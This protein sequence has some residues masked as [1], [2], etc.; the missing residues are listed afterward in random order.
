VPSAAQDANTIDRLSHRSDHARMPTPCR[1]LLLALLACGSLAVHAQQGDAAPASAASAATPAQSLE[2]LDDRLDALKAALKDKQAASSLGDLRNDALAV[3][4]QARQLASDLAPQLAALQA[5]LDVL[6]PPPAKGAAPE[7]PQVAAQRRQ[8]DKAGAALDARIKQAQLLGQNALQLA[9]QITGMRNDAFQARLA[10]R[11]ASPFGRAFWSEPARS[12]P[13][14]LARLD[15]LGGR[16][17]DAWSEAWETPN[18]TP[19]L[20]CLIGAL[21][22]LGVGRWLL[23]RLLWRLATRHVPDGHLRRSAM[24][25]A[26]A[27]TALLTTGIAAQLAYLGLNWNDILAPDL[28]ALARSAVR[29]VLFAAFVTGLGR[30]LLSVRRPSWRL[31]PLSDL[32]AQRL[33]MLPWLLGAAALLFGLVERISR[34]IGSSLPTTVATR[35]AVALVVSGLIAAGW[36]RLRGARRQAAAEGVV[37]HQPLWV[38][39]LGAGAVL[40]VLVSWLGVATGYIALAFFAA[41]QMLWVGV[42]VA[43]AWLLGHLLNDLIHVA[44]SPHERGGQRLQ[45][46]FQLAP[47]ALD[48]AATLLAGIAK[49][50]LTLLAI[51]IVLTPFGA[52][53]GDLLASAL[54]T[55]GNLKLG[56]LP[57][58]PGNIFRAVLVLVGGGV[59]LHMLKRWLREQLLPKSTM[60]PGMQDSIVTLLGYLGGL[61]VLVLTLAALHVNLTSITWIVSALSV[62]IGFGLQAIVQ[63]FISGL[64]LLVERPVKVGD[65]VSLNEVEGDIRRINVRATEIQLWDRSTVIVP[66]SQL[67]TENVRN[68]TQANAL[69]RVQIK[70]PMPLDTDADKVRALALEVLGAHPGTLAAPAP[71]VQLE[72]LDAG[73]MTFNCV[74]YVGSPRD[75][76]GVKSDLLFELLQRLR[77]A[78]LPLVRAQLVRTLPPLAEED[79]QTG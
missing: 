43:S 8:L 25:V 10:S 12:F 65:W 7:A 3:Q 62:G 44:L 11:T 64:I 60:E 26:V 35:G 16:V 59:L 74:A 52:G 56:D 24:A 66:N 34:T 23:D 55:F 63:N 33:R 53:P 79:E 54:R 27:L 5:Q 1:F 2:Q 4:D 70:L 39:A 40:G 6:G 72:G 61:L 18:R 76:G 47:H 22:W 19:L 77:R 45:A 13:D 32:A 68:V 75:T 28:D 73:S 42:V 51:A 21:L 48:Q 49:V 17:A 29:L 78:R 9:A 67:I 58:N 38:G 15:R 14:D 69:G 37:E 31:P 36:W 57:I 41:V 20:L 50:L 46:S 71:Y 30:A